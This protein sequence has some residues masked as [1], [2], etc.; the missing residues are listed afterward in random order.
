VLFWL[1]LLS[2]FTG[3]SQIHANDDLR[4]T[5]S[6]KDPKFDSIIVASIGNRNITAQE[7]LFNYEF[8]PAFTRRDKDSRQRYLNFI[9]YEKLLALEG[10]TRHIDTTEGAR[11]TLAEIEGDLAT[12]ELYKDDVRGK[13][14]ITEEE[15]DDGLRKTQINLT[16]KWLY[17][18]SDDEATRLYE[19]F[20][21]GT[22]F[23]SLFET[24]LSDS[25]K[26][27][28]R[29]IETTRFK[30]E[31]ANPV[32]AHVLDTLHDGTV[33]TP[34]KVPDGYYIIKVVDRSKNLLMT[35]SENTQLH[36]DV[37]RA[38][39]QQKSDSLSDLYLQKIMTGEHPSIIRKP[40]DLLQ[41]YLAKKILSPQEFSNWKLTERLLERWGQF[42]FMNIAKYEEQKLVELSRH[43]YTVKD[44]LVWYRAREYNIRLDISSPKAFFVSF[45]Q[46]IWRMVRDKLLI[47]RAI[48]RGLQKRDNVKKQMQWWMD[49]VVYKLVRGGIVDSIQLNDSLLNKYHVDH[50][51]R[52]L[53][54]N[55]TLIP[56]EKAKENVLRDFYSD[57]LTKRLLHRI[58]QLKER[59]KVNVHDKELMTLPIDDD[60][61]PSAID[62]YVVKKGG[63]FPR[64]AF[65]SIDYEWQTWN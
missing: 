7:F 23:D 20:I 8:G 43:T 18:R 30:L 64:P 48:N 42:D 15:I 22:A 63:T 1:L 12:E 44:Y 62:V 37:E 45:E 46:T 16:V 28:D 49:K 51:K 27:E 55:G 41:T 21:G 4:K 36:S 11:Q 2:T 47:E 33:S 61:N 57:E 35:E 39:A 17:T 25:V 38:L 40:F 10:Y 29:S 60:F 56:F 5:F 34:I 50:Q 54:G 52:Y 9:I 26:A 19:K 58:L 53:D 59:Y 3:Y 24:Q 6:F 31:M 14:K 65:P 13:V 32:L